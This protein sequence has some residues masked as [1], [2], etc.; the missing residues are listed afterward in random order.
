MAEKLVL[1][2][3]ML[4][5]FGEE[6]KPS[7]HLKLRI[8][9]SNTCLSSTLQSSSPSS[10]GFYKAWDLLFCSAEVEKIDSVP[11]FHRRT[12]YREAEEMKKTW[13]DTHMQKLQHT[14]TLQWGYQHSCRALYDETE[15]AVKSPWN[16]KRKVTSNK[17]SRMVWEVQMQEGLWHVTP[18]R[19]DY[20][21]LA[22]HP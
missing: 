2:S 4:L 9:K 13:I 7:H 20:H 8:G 18:R 14:T 21:F 17:G 22:W 16:Y 6:K 3:A 12:N 10:A 1:S 5:I 15:T 19:C 11:Y